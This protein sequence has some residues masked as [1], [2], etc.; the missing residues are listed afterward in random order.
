MKLTKLFIFCILSLL[1]SVYGQ[2]Q[3]IIVK[4]RI[5]DEKG[6]SI[7]G[8]SILIKGISKSTTSD[9]DGDY[10]IKAPTDGSLTISYVGYKTI[11]EPINGRT[12]IDLKLVLSSQDLQE[13]VVVGYGT[14]KK[15][16]VTGSISSVKAKDLED[17][18]I[19]RI[20][21]SLQGRVSGV[22]IAANS[23]APGSSA[24]VRVRG[25]TSLGNNDPLWVIDGVVVDNGGIGFLNQSDIESVE[26]L[27]DAAS[28]AI[29]GARSAAGV[30]LITTKKGK[31]GKMS[32]SYSGFS[33][34]SSPARKLKMLN[35]TEYAT[36][37]NES[38]AASNLPLQFPNPESYGVGT[39]WQE[40]IFNDRAYRFG[41]DV[42]LSGGN[43]VSTFYVSFGVLEQEGIV[44]SKVSSYNRKNIRLNS[45][46]K[47]SKL[48]TF[49]QTL[50]YS[51]EKNIGFG[52]N[53]E[54]G[55]ILSSAINL[56]PTTPLIE[57][58]PIKTNASPYTNVGV[59][60]DSNGNPYGI[61]KYVAQE[62]S[63]PLANIQTMLGNYG[64][65]DNFVGNAYLELE[66]MKGLKFRSTLGAKLAYY[67]S[68][69]FTPVSFFNSSNN[70]PINNISSSSNQGFGWNIE[71]IV[72]YAK[73]FKDHDFTVL[74]GQGHYID[75]I[76]DGKG[77]TY[78][79]LPITSYEDASFGYGTPQ[80][81]I[82]AY[83][84]EGSEHIVNS[85]FSRLNYDFK[86]KYLFTGIIRRDGSSRFGSNNRYGTFPSFSLGWVVSK[87]EFWKE[88]NIIN[89]LKFRGGYGVTGSD[90]IGDFK[91]LST[92]GGG[93]NY[94]IGTS[95]SVTVGYSPNSP[96]NPDLKWEETS[97][98][99]IGFE[100]RFLQDF[101]LSIDL[102]N[103]KTSGILQDIELPG[104]LGS[105][106]N[107]SANIADMLNKG[108]DIELGY[109]K[110]IGALNISAN[111]NVSYLQN[112]VTFLGNGI[113]FL[114]GGAGYQA[115]TYPLT[116]TQ[117]GQSV[118]SFYGF[119]TDGIFQNQAEVN[120]YTNSTG[121]L[122]QP[123]A[124]AGDFR[125]KDTDGDGTITEKD[126]AFI[127]SPL[128]DYAFGFTLNFEYNGF[129]A[130]V[131]GQGLT[132]NKIFQGLRRLDIANANYQTTALSRWTGEG[133]SNTFPRLTN[134]DPNKNFSNPSNFYLQAGDYVRIKTIQVGY[135]FPNE[136][137]KQV[138]MTRARIYVTGENLF[139][140]TKYTGFDP[141][142]GGG[143]DKGY[144]P[145]AKTLMLGLNLQF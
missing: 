107:P 38:R 21:Q 63:N 56:D 138:G 125:W 76:S 145:Q 81:N 60:R 89:L 55:G 137:I 133:T 79:N 8:V 29:Y 48:F 144:Y 1:F 4:G 129:D 7:P 54:F 94:T 139:T 121:G 132:G 35:A 117:V 2:A 108:F 17:L 85:Y 87:E 43:N 53:Y 14:Q 68:E 12:K 36:L 119:Q 100:A 11:Q 135:S 98:L 69:S 16:V 57:T 106:G 142:I 101:N 71:N 46:H 58:D 131:F 64:W 9:L 118:S 31:A 6:L 123:T 65:A 30:I 22:F 116:R 61:S 115:S 126:R 141:E 92:I 127:G 104:Y 32:V 52:S 86:E 45:T 25:I 95:G 88:N 128:P 67:G 97:Q 59:F 113:S 49:G 37:N 13:V 103:K 96:S 3:D 105:T 102:Y 80:E 124:A 70:N 44:A 5:I 82:D 84:Y 39:N 19:T 130:L 50:G 33:G 110:K 27:K 15:S 122:I 47:I 28:Q 83:A 140:F 134:D 73:N 10:E 66:A 77:V 78:K 51:R 120:A 26:V 111:A 18:P 90:A 143:I 91:Y 114:S 41:H 34:S 93:R 20:E 75:N 109:K 136:A 24:T 40:A 42:S 72:S 62:M 23:G 99:N 112:E 74:I